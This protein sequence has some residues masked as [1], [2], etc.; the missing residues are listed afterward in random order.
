MSFQEFLD[1]VKV[2][3]MLYGREFAEVLFKNNIDLFYKLNYNEI[4]ASVSKRKK[5]N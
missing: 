2:V 5:V 3:K 4:S 1:L